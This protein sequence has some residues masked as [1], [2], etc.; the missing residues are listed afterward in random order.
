MI[1]ALST[2]EFDQGLGITNLPKDLGASSQ[3]KHFGELLSYPSGS[4]ICNDTNLDEPLAFMAQHD[5]SKEGL[6]RHGRRQPRRGV[7]SAE[8]SAGPV[9]RALDFNEHRL[10]LKPLA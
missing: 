8:R 7:A 4:L 1:Q 10:G 2:N 6:E 9:T 3:G 5:E